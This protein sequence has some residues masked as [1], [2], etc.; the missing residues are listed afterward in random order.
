MKVVAAW[1]IVGRLL[2]IYNHV[3]MSMNCFYLRPRVISMTVVANLL[4]WLP[5]NAI[6]TCWRIWG[7]TSTR[8]ALYLAI[9]MTNPLRLRPRRSSL[10]LREKRVLGLV[11]NYNK[12]GYGIFRV[13][14]VYGG[15]LTVLLWLRMHGYCFYNKI[16]LLLFSRY[17]YAC[18]CE[19]I[20]TRAYMSMLMYV[21]GA[22]FWFNVWANV[23]TI[24]ARYVICQNQKYT[25][26]NVTNPSTM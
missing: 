9:V 25:S 14:F 23:E 19:S 1:M 16:D 22:I 8:V 12:G 21:F 13:C 11:K 10:R 3:Q 18:A 5:A 2:L 26:K 15:W 4:S 17:I 20:H 24:F 6:T 7:L